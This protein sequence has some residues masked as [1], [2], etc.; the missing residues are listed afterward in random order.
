MN[1]SQKIE[2]LLHYFRM[3]QKDFAE[4]CGLVTSNFSQIKAGKCRISK[5]L[6]EKILKAFPEV[7]KTWLATGEG[8]MLVNKTTNK[9]K[10]T[11][12]EIQKEPYSVPL[13]PID[14]VAGFGGEDIEGGRYED[15]EKYAVPEFEVAKAEFVIR[16]SGSSMYPKYSNGD[17][18]AC[19]KIYDILFFQWGKVYVIDSSQ[20]M[21]VKRV[22]KCDNEDYITLVSDNSERYPPFDI[23]KSDVRSLSIVLGV[24][25][26]E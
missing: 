6:S 14:A 9:E 1:D 24:I 26:M 12:K 20:G 23:P 13:I 18:L 22:F 10:E 19:R 8:E 25:R 15:C 11:E 7:N 17:I 5:R 21:L 4:K 3:E 2:E 16:V